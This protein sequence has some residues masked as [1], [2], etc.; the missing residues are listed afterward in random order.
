MQKKV[1]LVSAILGS[2]ILFY[3]SQKTQDERIVSLSEE[4]ALSE[5][6]LS[7]E[8]PLAMRAEEL[9]VPIVTSRVTASEADAEVEALLPISVHGE[10]PAEYSKIEAYCRV[11]AAHLEIPLS[12]DV[13]VVS[14]ALAIVNGK[15]GGREVMVSGEGCAEGT[16][17]I[18]KF[19]LDHEVESVLDC[20]HTTRQALIMSRGGPAYGGDDELPSPPGELYVTSR[21]GLFVSSCGGPVRYFMNGNFRIKN[22][23]LL[24]ADGCE[25]MDRSGQ[26]I[27]IKDGD[28]PDRGG[29]FK[30]SQCIA[31]V[32]LNEKSFEVQDEHTFIA[33]GNPMD[34]LVAAEEA[35]LVEGQVRFRNEL[36]ELESPYMPNIPVLAKRDCPVTF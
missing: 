24:D 36:T 25:V 32:N 8:F 3:N 13:R 12:G 4:L 14:S 33:T 18:V 2:A 20:R 11:K 27:R 26:K 7:S 22:D 10:F 1:L 29:C 15:G 9:A 31:L 34:I 6:L 30:N 16:Y 19:N 35:Y 23:V 21:N 28:K 17:S 5:A